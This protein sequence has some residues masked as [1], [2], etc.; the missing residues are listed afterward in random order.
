MGSG[1][2]IQF[3][4]DNWCGDQPLK[5]LFLVLFEIVTDN[6]AFV[7]SL[8]ERQVEGWSRNC[9]VEFIR[10]FNNWEID[11]LA[12]FFTFVRLCDLFMRNCEA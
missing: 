8:L 2:Q 1:S 11:E 5:L 10:N 9:C 12:S 4:H 7:E 3:W 6:N